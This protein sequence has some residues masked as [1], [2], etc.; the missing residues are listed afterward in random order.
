M[1]RP[2]ELADEQAWLI[3]ASLITIAAVA[4]GVALVY[5]RPVMVPFVL[6]VF[7]Y[8]LVSPIADLLE[9]RAHL[10][11]W[12]SAL[13]TLLV[14]AGLI[15]VTG[16]LIVASTRGLLDSVDIYR[17][18]LIQ[19]ARRVFQILDDR[20]IDLGQAAFVETI[21]Q[22]PM[23]R[24]VQTSAAT[25]FTLVTNGFL[26]LIFVIFL[27]LGHQ[28]EMVKSAVFREIDAQVRRFLVLKFAISAATGVLV[29]VILAILGLELALV[30]GVLTFFLNFIPSV[31]SIVAVLLPIPI[32][33][34]QFP[35]WWPVFGVL[36]LP[37]IV[38]V[39]IGNFLDPK[40]M[41]RGLDLSPVTILLA[42]VF[43]GLVWGIVG[44]LLAVPMTAILR[45]VLAQFTTTRP[46]SE[47][48]AGRLPPGG[49][50]G[51]WETAPSGQR[52]R[53]AS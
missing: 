10:P 24:I 22:L 42:L 2:W 47:L 4:T 13:T 5:T 9:S 33:L 38:Q 51:V 18:R 48:L 34:V 32:A 14:V 7:V 29:G 39:T 26:V 8:Y 41:G 43:W 49:A 16:L 6:A 1:R 46:V 36:A 37:S 35:G 45:I 30:F 31:G 40:L 12:A 44:M 3:T 11:R 21:R 28:R 52:A 20:G 25:A 19:M 53:D 50:S 23:A 15:V 27:L 17:E